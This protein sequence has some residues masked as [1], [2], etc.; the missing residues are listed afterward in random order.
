[1]DYEIVWTEPAVADLEAITAFIAQK[2]PLAAERIGQGI[3]A[4]VEILRSFPSIGPIY[5][6][7]SRG[8]HRQI[9]YKMYRIFYRVSEELKRVEI[10]T[11][12]HSAREE[13]ELTG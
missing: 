13:P 7:G 2:S 10:L 5:P 6:P 8:P 1:M 4:H 11:V 3:L 12:W 9:T